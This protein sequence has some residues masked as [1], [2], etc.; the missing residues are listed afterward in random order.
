MTE[1]ERER[2]TAQRQVEDLNHQRESITSY[3]DELRS[4]LGHEPVPTTAALEKA[5]KAEAAFAVTGSERPVERKPRTVKST[6]EVKD[7]PAKGDAAEAEP[8]APA[9]EKDP[10]AEAAAVAQVDADATIQEIVHEAATAASGKGPAEAV[11]PAD[12]DL[13]DGMASNPR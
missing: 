8:K 9:V 7:Q 1:A 13:T 3:L 5:A 6:P 10:I 4:L 2:T 12:A 11:A